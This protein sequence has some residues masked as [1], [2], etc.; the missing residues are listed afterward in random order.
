MNRKLVWILVFSLSLA[1]VAHGQTAATS[2]MMAGSGVVNCDAGESLNRALSKLDKHT[3]ATLMVQGTCTEYVQIAGFENLTVKSITGATLVQ[4]STIPNNLFLTLL[5]IDASRS[6]LID[7]LSV[8]STPSGI[9]PVGIG[10]SSIDVRLR[11]LTIQGGNPGII[12]FE[13]S[14]VSLAQVTVRDPGYAAI[15]IYD[16][17]DVHIEHC[18]LENTTGALWHQGVAVG[19]GHVTMY[20]TTIRNMQIGINLFGSGSVDINAFNAYYPI[21]GTS[22]VVIDSPAGTNFWG[23]SIVGLGA[24]NVGSAKLRIINPGQPWGGETGGVFVS[25]GSTMTDIASL[26]VVSG[27]QGQGV[28]VSNNSY[29]SLVGSSITGSSH[30]GLVVVNSSTVAVGQS[31]PLTLIGGNAPDVFCDAKSQISGG[32]NLAGVPSVS[33]ANLLPGDSVP[34]P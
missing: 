15:G 6:V 24:L 26:L 25:G 29:A 19:S 10:K 31:T 5:R 13:N 14:Q 27:S 12:V 4:P 17:S 1:A 18:W 21:G 8:L 28:L 16:L 30:G 3:P 9:P 11:N 2:A 34:L 23:V 33:C 20:A 22:D 7:G 32:A